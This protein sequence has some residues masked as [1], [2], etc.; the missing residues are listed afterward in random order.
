MMT[1]TEVPTEVSDSVIN[2]ILSVHDHLF[3]TSDRYLLRFR[4]LFS[5]FLY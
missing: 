2:I 4:I 3:V 5:L 1:T